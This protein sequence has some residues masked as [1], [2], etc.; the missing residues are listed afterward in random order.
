MYV[1]P[2][3]FFKGKDSITIHT[4]E[5]GFYPKDF[6]FG[7]RVTYVMVVCARCMSLCQLMNDECMYNPFHFLVTQG[8]KTLMLEPGYRNPDMHE[9]LNAIWKKVGCV[10]SFDFSMQV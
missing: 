4:N 1:D 9:N 7:L 2:F 3:V 8:V 5:K 10:F 6:F